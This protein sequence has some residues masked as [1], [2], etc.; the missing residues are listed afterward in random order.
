MGDKKKYKVTL[1]SAS[2]SYSV[3]LEEDE[4]TTM[5]ELRDAAAKKIKEEYGFDVPPDEE[6]EIEFEI[7]DGK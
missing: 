5:K 4:K 1:Q 2:F 3:V 7:V 6:L